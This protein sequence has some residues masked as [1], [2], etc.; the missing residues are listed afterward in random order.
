MKAKRNEPKGYRDNI[1]EGREFDAELLMGKTIGRKRREPYQ[2]LRLECMGVM[3]EEKEQL[4][5]ATTFPRNLGH[6]RNRIGHT[7]KMLS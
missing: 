2:I 7:R 4:E 3:N 5:V 1:L 6:G